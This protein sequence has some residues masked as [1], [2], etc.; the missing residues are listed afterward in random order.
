MDKV[1]MVAVGGGLGA[2]L[3]YWGAA[4]AGRMMGAGFMGTMAVNVIGSFAMG[5]LAVVLIERFPGSW[6]KFA[7]FIM[8]GVLGGFTTFSA[9]SLDAL[10]LIERG[11][12][13]MASGY[14]AGSVLLSILG[15]AA[16]LFLTRWWLP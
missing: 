8:T 3:R 16:G 15:L 14:V 6:G 1:V 4:W 2:V 9:F 5:I 11:R 7:P 13:L 12:I 10:Q